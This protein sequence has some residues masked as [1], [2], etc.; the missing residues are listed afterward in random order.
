MGTIGNR[1]REERERRGIGIEEVEA[2][3]KIRARYLLALED[4]RFADL[5]DPAY[6][7][8][9][10]RDY[11]DELGMDSQSLLD[12]MGE[13]EPEL[14][15]EIVS[16]FPPEPLS[17]VRTLVPTRWLLA[18]A[19]AIAIVAAMIWAGSRLGSGTGQDAASVGG[20][21]QAAHSGPSGGSPPPPTSTA[22]PPGT[23]AGST[24]Q[25]IAFT[26][27]AGPCWLEVRAGSAT[28]AILFQ[29]ML[30]TNRT[31]S[32]TRRRVWAR[33]GAPWN[34]RVHVGSQ[35]LA[36]PIADTGDLVVTHSGAAAAA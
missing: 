22:Q 18:A 2:H 10:V 21:N 11:A 14:P 17:R 7:R 29:G 26:T 4:E 30:A 20:S 34:L 3:T 6:A 24:A 31:L 28:G 19:V 32:F 12:E 35:R 8:A 1:L 36:L 27:S 5:P 16:D 33:V 23:T 9:F 13:P 15:A 25:P